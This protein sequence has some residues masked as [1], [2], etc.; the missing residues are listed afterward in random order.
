MGPP[1]AR[2]AQR[3]AT[4]DPARRPCLV[5]LD[6]I[7]TAP[8]AG[9]DR[10]EPRWQP[11]SERPAI[12]AAWPQAHRARPGHPLGLDRPPRRDLRGSR[13]LA[14]PRDRAL[15]PIGGTGAGPSRRSTARFPCPARTGDGRRRNDNLVS[16]VV[17]SLLPSADSWL[18]DQ[19]VHRREYEANR[20]LGTLGQR[21]AMEANH[22]RMR[23]ALH[24][25]GAKS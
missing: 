11:S 22:E 21:L 23:K 6:F 15:R 10:D 20:Q 2:R 14:P 5:D 7:A 16:R 13:A 19:V 9:P 24:D 8:V 18:C 3:P 12:E 17:D 25:Q 4:Q 1:K